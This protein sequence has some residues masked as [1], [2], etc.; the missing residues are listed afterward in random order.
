ML[1]KSFETLETSD[2]T[3]SLIP[4]SC[5]SLSHRPFI[6]S[7]HS[8]FESSVGDSPMPQFVDPLSHIPEDHLL[9]ASVESALLMEA[10]SNI[11]KNQEEV[12]N[13]QF[14]LSLEE[15]ESRDL[16]YHH[17]H[18]L[19][20]S[21]DPSSRFDSVP[22]CSNINTIRLRDSTVSGSVS[23]CSNIDNVRLRD[24]EVRSEK[25]DSSTNKNYQI[26]RSSRHAHLVQ[27]MVPPLNNLATTAFRHRAKEAKKR[28]EARHFNSKL[29]S[30]LKLSTAL[31]DY[32]H[33][34]RHPP[35]QVAL[36]DVSID[37]SIEE[38]FSVK[39]RDQYVID[40][41][42]GAEKVFKSFEVGSETP[43]SYP[44]T[45]KLLSSTRVPLEK[46]DSAKEICNEIDETTRPT[47]EL[48][49]RKKLDRFN[50]L[51][52]PPIKT[53]S[54]RREARKQLTDL[55]DRIDKVVACSVPTSEIFSVF[56]FKNPDQ[57]A[58]CLD[59][60]ARNAL[61]TTPISKLNQESRESLFRSQQYLMPT[62]S[63]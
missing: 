27:T 10:R 39:E 48:K 61:F 17:L 13:K 23:P 33:W 49:S 55:K 3:S 21:A 47:S 52:D 20:S 11:L 2:S 25:E 19:A 45:E 18:P 14:N 41:K 38:L 60:V 46:Q 29:V 37:S 15:E 43:L 12:Q 1:E 7:V 5:D 57:P 32:D 31:D 8:L 26:T 51:I 44:L 36:N 56:D 4:P 50:Q 58:P 28:K 63:Y 9:H 59:H 40:A 35:E 6:E 54:L 53:H 30:A 22:P 16:I 34:C 62:C 42:L 24:S